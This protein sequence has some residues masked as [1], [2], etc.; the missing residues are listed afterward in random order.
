M[1][2][3]ENG[4]IK[5]FNTAME[6][7]VRQSQDE[8]RLAWDLV[9]E[10]GTT[11]SS[12]RDLEE[13][14]KSVDHINEVTELAKSIYDQTVLPAIKAAAAK[15]RQHGDAN[16]DEIADALESGDYTGLAL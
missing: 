11:S 9:K 5:D 8:Y 1:A 7:Y 6:L 10:H 14:A 2:Y 3:F 4:T 13:A 12:H 16:L 15:M